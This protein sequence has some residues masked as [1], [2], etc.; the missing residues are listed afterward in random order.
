MGVGG[1]G[2]VTGL[3]IAGIGV[4]AGGTLEGVALAGIGVGAPSIEGLVAAGL[5]AGTKE[6]RGVSIALAYFNIQPEGRMQGVSIAAWNRIQGRQ[7]GL[8]I[9]ILNVA[10]E[11][12]GLQVGLINIARNKESFSVLPLFNYS[13]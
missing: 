4:G 3:T 5:G 2:D 8:T 10:E 9:G 7:D 11:L 12:H 1:G 6:L 13:R